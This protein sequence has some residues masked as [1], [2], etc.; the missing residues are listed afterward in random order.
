MVRKRLFFLSENFL[1]SMEWWDQVTV[2]PEEMRIIVFI[3]GISKG[4]KGL[5]PKG[6]QSC[7]ISILGDSEE[8]KYAQKKEKKNSTSEMINKIIPSRIPL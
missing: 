7:P 2:N 6:G 4:L 8:W 3:R 5:I 1:L